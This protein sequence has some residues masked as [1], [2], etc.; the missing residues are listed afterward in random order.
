MFTGIIQKV[1]TVEQVTQI[2]GR[3]RF[4]LDLGELARE[5][6]VGDSV[7]VSGVCLTATTINGGS[8]TFDVV[9]ETVKKTNLSKL[10]AG[11]NINIE[12]ALRLGDR[13]GGHLVSGHVDGQGKIRSIRKLPG[14]VR[15]VVDTSPALMKHVIEKGSVAIDGISLTVAAVSPRGFEVAL[16]P[17]TMENTTLK[18]AGAGRAVNLECDMIGRW[19]AKMVVGTPRPG[20]GQAGDSPGDLPGGGA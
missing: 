10:R 6:A 7:A 2:Q 4:R 1:G 5:V 16:I 15:L 9:R 19:V 17:H 20:R 11:S 14:E 3:I 8:V 18:D 12:L 13:L